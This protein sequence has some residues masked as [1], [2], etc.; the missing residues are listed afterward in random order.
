MKKYNQNAKTKSEAK[1]RAKELAD[2]LK[3]NIGGNWK[4]FVW[5]NLGWHYKAILGT[6]N[7][8]F[9]GYNKYSCMIGESVDSIGSPVYW[10]RSVLFTTPKKAV[11]FSMVQADSFI[12]KVTDTMQTNKDLITKKK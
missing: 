7:V 11:V 12:K 1:L 5:S 4:P 9:D 10:H 6:M 3:K 2:Y 8:Y